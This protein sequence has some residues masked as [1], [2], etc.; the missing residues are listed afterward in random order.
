MIRNHAPI[1]L[2]FSLLTLS[3]LQSSDGALV[4]GG[5]GLMTQAY[6][7]QVET[8]LEEGSVTFTNIYTKQAGDSSVDFHTAVD[9]KGRT[10]TLIE[11]LAGEIT[12]QIPGNIIAQT[13]ERQVIGGYNPQSWHSGGSFNITLDPAPRDAFIFNLADNSVHIQNT[14]TNGQYQTLNRDGP[15]FGGG[16]DIYVDSS[17]TGGH[18]DNY[19]YSSNGL[20]SFSDSIIF[21]SSAFRDLGLQIGRIEVFTISAS[22]TSQAV[23]EQ[24]S[25]ALW[26]LGGL[27]L[28]VIPFRRRS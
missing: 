5:G 22:E 26:L 12:S 13:I 10:I 14:T 8:W 17:L 9:G 1:L 11:V 24:S 16:H 28:A 2:M 23:P 18:A 6:A 3:M 15:T 19:S 27:G 25:L 20:E 4:V 7:N 21:G